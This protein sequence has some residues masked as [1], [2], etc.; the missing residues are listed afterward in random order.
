MLL[1]DPIRVSSPD[2]PRSILDAFNRRAR[3]EPPILRMPSRKL[4]EE[5][6]WD[7]IKFA[8]EKGLL[9]GISVGTK[10]TFQKEDQ[11]RWLE[12]LESSNTEERD[13]LLSPLQP[14]LNPDLLVVA[15]R[16]LK[17]AT[18]HDLFRFARGTWNG[19]DGADKW[20]AC[21]EQSLERVRIRS[22]RPGCAE[23]KLKEVESGASKLDLF[24]Y[25]AFTFSFLQRVNGETFQC[26]GSI[27]ESMYHFTEQCPVHVSVCYDL[28]QKAIQ[29]GDI[30]PLSNGYDGRDSRLR[31][32]LASNRDPQIRVLWRE[33]SGASSNGDER[34]P[35]DHVH[36]QRRIREVP[37]DSLVP[38]AASHQAAECQQTYGG[39]FVRGLCKNWMRNSCHWGD[40]CKYVHLQETPRNGCPLPDG[41]AEAC[42]ISDAELKDALW[43]NMKKGH[44]RTPLLELLDSLRKKRDDQEIFQMLQDEIRKENLVLLVA[45]SSAEKA[46]YWQNEVL[47]HVASAIHDSEVCVL[48]SPVLRKPPASLME[49]LMAHCRQ[50]LLSPS[51]LHLRRVCFSC[52]ALRIQSDGITKLAKYVGYFVNRPDHTKQK[53]S[54]KV[55]CHGIK[56]QNKWAPS[57]N[58]AQRKQDMESF[59]GS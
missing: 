40:E 49:C 10:N 59:I 46:Y 35:E 5:V 12:M 15:L 57:Y 58:I 21:A 9:W 22:L 4:R 50:E 24:N 30:V 16:M 44:L 31:V 26:L 23:V 52:F 8:W 20:K 1:G 14:E 43:K 48:V 55:C 51:Y 34:V 6:P 18:Y 47:Q 53:S 2:M 45:A 54:W 56:F 27:A 42:A 36:N 41:L 7:E 25:E 33:R 28:I 11:E 17:V 39:S 13:I 19:Q 32:T 29:S 37:L 3:Q 38:T